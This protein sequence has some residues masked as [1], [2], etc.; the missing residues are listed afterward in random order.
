MYTNP[1]CRWNSQATTFYGN[2]WY[3]CT[4]KKTMYDICAHNSLP[5]SAILALG[6]LEKKKEK[7]WWTILRGQQNTFFRISG[8]SQV[9]FGSLKGCYQRKYYCRECLYSQIS[10]KVWDS[11][12][13]LE[14]SSRLPLRHHIAWLGT[15]SVNPGIVVN[16]YASAHHPHTTI[17]IDE[18]MIFWPSEYSPIEVGSTECSRHLVFESSLHVRLL[19]ATLQCGSNLTMTCNFISSQNWVSWIIST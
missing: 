11:E 4:R 13:K 8:T 19:P 7:R 17:A 18:W 3:T 10:L 2:Q 16:F 14:F 15:F 1:Q 12:E 9:Y 5:T 6:L